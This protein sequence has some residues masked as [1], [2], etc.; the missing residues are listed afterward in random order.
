MFD[1]FA[2][3]FEKH[4]N[5]YATSL[6]LANLGEEKEKKAAKDLQALMEKAVAVKMK[7]GA[8][9]KE[10]PKVASSGLIG[11]LPKIPFPNPQF[12]CFSKSVAVRYNVDMGRHPVAARNIRAGELILV[13]DPPISFIAEDVVGHLCSQCFMKT[14]NFLPSPFNTRVNSVRKFAEIGLLGL[15]FLLEAGHHS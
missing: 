3:E 11:A 14:I 4:V 7:K 8:N 15:I 1:Y 13:E 9:N 5:D 6:R 10:M 12:P 2:E